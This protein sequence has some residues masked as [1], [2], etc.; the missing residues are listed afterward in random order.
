MISEP[1]LQWLFSMHWLMRSPLQSPCGA[2]PAGVWCVH[3]EGIAFKQGQIGLIRNATTLSC[4]QTGNKWEAYL[5]LLEQRNTEG[6]ALDLL[7]LKRY[8]GRAAATSGMS[9]LTLSF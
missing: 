8:V 1:A 4:T 2:S 9:V 6:E 5:G 3:S 7:G